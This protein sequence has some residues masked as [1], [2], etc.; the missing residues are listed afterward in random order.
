MRGDPSRSAHPGGPGTSPGARHTGLHT[1][2]PSAGGCVMRGFRSRQLVLARECD[3][4][5]PLLAAWSSSCALISSLGRTNEA[6]L[7]RARVTQKEPQAGR[8]APR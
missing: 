3:T 7:Q 1:G 8:S 6:L 4:L 2:P 5:C